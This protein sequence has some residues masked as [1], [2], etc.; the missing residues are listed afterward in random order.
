MSLL[1]YPDSP[2]FAAGT[3][4]HTTDGIATLW[5]GIRVLD[6]ASLAPRDVFQAHSEH[7]HELVNENPLRYWSGGYRY[8]L[9]MTTLAVYVDVAAMGT[10]VSPRIQVQVNG[11][12]R[13]DA[14]LVSGV[15]LYSA[16]DM[17][18]WGLVD[19]QVA[20]VFMQIIDTGRL[21]GPDLPSGSTWG[22][23]YLV[24]AFVAPASAIMGA[25]AWPGTP[26]F[27]AS[28]LPGNGPTQAALLQL[29][30]AADW[31]AR[32][33][34]CVPSPLAQT[35]V[36]TCDG[37]ATWTPEPGEPPRHLWSGGAIRGPF[38]R[39]RCR[40]VWVA[41]RTAET[42]RIRLKIGGSEVATTP[43]WPA[44]GWGYHDFDVNLGAYSA[45]AL[46]RIDLEWMVTG[47]SLGA[48]AVLPRLTVQWVELHRSAATYATLTNRPTMYESSTWAARRA[49]LNEMSAALTTI[50]NRVT[51][52]VDRW[53]RIRLFRSSYAYNLGEAATLHGQYHA[54]RRHRAGLRLIVRGSNLK[55]GWGAAGYTL[56]NP[57]EPYGQYIWKWASE[58]TVVSGSEVQTREIF[59]DALEGL[60]PGFQYVIYGAD[61]RYAA[62]ELR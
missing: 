52:D 3:D 60:E 12:T 2:Y 51:A 1:A 46:L 6:M 27:I 13:I 58:E 17:A 62:E 24:D 11:V 55:V 25:D 59:L 14:A 56:A 61:C 54:V 22:T 35:T 18:A 7:R 32:R 48:A 28:P 38:D 44:S 53:D 34:A 40:V 43:S 33:L 16:A 41:S 19:G 42:Q 31:L 21:P 37:L 5:D 23:Y 15:G 49:Q 26:A 45:T 29:G 50:Y 39:L 8:R 20:E 9:G 10:A 47:P 4:M 36:G 57:K 30:N